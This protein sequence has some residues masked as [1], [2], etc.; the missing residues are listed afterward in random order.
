MC[1]FCEAYIEGTS[2]QWDYE[3][4]FEL[5]DIVGSG[6]LREPL[7]LSMFEWGRGTIFYFYKIRK[8]V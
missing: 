6:L 3:S 4:N 8:T 5:H 7:S 2:I 1:E